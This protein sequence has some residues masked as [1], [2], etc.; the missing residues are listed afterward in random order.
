VLVGRIYLS[1]KMSARILEN[2]A[3]KRAKDSPIERLSDRELEVFHLIGRGKSTVQ[4]AEELHLSTKTIES[5]RAN[6]KEK[7]NLR[8]MPELISFASRWVES[9]DAR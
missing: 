3:G 4:I 8:T 9:Q 1:D 5:H 6:V 2:V 7:L